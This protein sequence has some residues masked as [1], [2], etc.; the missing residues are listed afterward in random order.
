MTGGSG[1]CADDVA[2]RA[3]EVSGGRRVSEALASRIADGRWQIEDCYARLGVVACKWTGVDSRLRPV[4]LNSARL[5]RAR[6]G[7]SGRTGAVM[8]GAAILLF[9]LC[10]L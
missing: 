1:S 9:V 10:H 3:A 8:Q 2:S 6:S 4:V 7:P 5:R